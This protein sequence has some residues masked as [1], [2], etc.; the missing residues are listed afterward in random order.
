MP[1]M[2][3]QPPRYT[4]PP[5]LSTLAIPPATLFSRNSHLATLAIGAYIFTPSSP[6]QL[7]LLRRSPTDSFPNRWEV[8]GGGTEPSDATLLDT[9]VREVREETGLSVVAITAEL[10]WVEF[11]GRR[12]RGRK[13]DFVVEVGEGEVK[14]NP[15]EHTA[16][17]W[18][19]VEEVGGLEITTEGHREA[20]RRAFERIQAIR[21]GDGAGVGG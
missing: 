11:V 9:V 13:Y 15:E 2:T 8:P 12:G 3:D 4:Y 6:P 19:G 21:G 5:T 7:L 14:T 10:G 16:W 17:R 1:D 20:V 18:C